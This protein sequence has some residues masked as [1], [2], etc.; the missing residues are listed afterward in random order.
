MRKQNEQV[1][2][3][4]PPTPGY[5]ACT[6][7]KGHDGPCAHHELQPNVPNRPE[8]TTAGGLRLLG[9]WL[10]ECL[11]LG[12]SKASLDDLEALFWKYRDGSGRLKSLNSGGEAMNLQKLVK[13]R[14]QLDSNIH[15]QVTLF[16]QKLHAAGKFAPTVTKTWGGGVDTIVDVT[17]DNAGHVLL[18]CTNHF[19][20]DVKPYTVTYPAHLI[21]S[22]DD[23]AI[24]AY[25]ATLEP[26]RRRGDDVQT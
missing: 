26:E 14:D 6:R 17:V 18:H 22:L 9:V 10:A 8:H 1:C 23:A 24:A 16:L 4:V 5:A 25:V 7:A 2:G 20:G 21:D 15:N 3:F 19:R 11:K 13:A 12:W